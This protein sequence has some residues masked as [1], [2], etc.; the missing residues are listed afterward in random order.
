MLRF[1]LAV[2]QVGG[3][4][5][6]CVQAQIGHPFCLMPTGMGCTHGMG[7]QNKQAQACA[8]RQQVIHKEGN[9]WGGIRKG[10]VWWGY[11]GRRHMCKWG[12]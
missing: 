11:R 3:S 9:G 2:L 7:G 6:H 5:V 1:K 8:C 12:R 4:K 10:G